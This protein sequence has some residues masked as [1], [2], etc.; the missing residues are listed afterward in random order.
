M[1]YFGLDGGE[2]RRKGTWIVNLKLISLKK[3]LKMKKRGSFKKG[4]RDKERR[5]E[6]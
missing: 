3:K 2:K 5:K 1:T 4:Y 6:R